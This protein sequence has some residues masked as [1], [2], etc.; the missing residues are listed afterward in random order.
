ME[1]LKIVPS[2][3]IELFAEH[4]ARFTGLAFVL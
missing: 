4:F 1:A 2:G 3:C